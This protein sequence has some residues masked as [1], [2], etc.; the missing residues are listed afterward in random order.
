MFF[1][2][3]CLGGWSENGLAGPGRTINPGVLGRRLSVAP[4]TRLTG[5][6]SDADASRSSGRGAL[7]L[8][9]V[10]AK[11]DNSVPEM[12]KAE[13]RRWLVKGKRYR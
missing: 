4:Q 8:S 6:A 1:F 12:G 13:V 9:A 10:S 5:Q 11:A 3:G 2:S 7:V